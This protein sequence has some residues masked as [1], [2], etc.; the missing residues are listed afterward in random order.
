MREILFRAKTTDKG[1]WV[2]GFVGQDTIIGKETYLATIIRTK[3]D[4]L[5]GGEWFEVIPET[6]GQFTG[7]IDKNGKKIFEEDIVKITYYSIPDYKET[8][9]RAV[10]YD[11]SECCYYPM[12]WKDYCEICDSYTNIDEIEVIGNIHDNPELL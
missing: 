8:E 10:T 7:L 4:K 11:E 5:Y 9:I 6:I 12:R 1:K 3:T 2:Y